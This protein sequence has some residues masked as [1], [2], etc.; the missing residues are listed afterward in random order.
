MSVSAD[1]LSPIAESPGISS[2]C[3]IERVG[4]RYI[5]TTKLLMRQL[6]DNNA[7]ILHISPK[8]ATVH[9]HVAFQWSLQMRGTIFVSDEEEQ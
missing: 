7:M 8:F 9:G 3:T 4:F 2:I 6:N 5:W 1:I